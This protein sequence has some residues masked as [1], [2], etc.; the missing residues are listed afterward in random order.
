MEYGL[1]TLLIISVFDE[2]TEAWGLDSLSEEKLIVPFS[3]DYGG[4]PYAGI[5]KK[6]KYYS[7]KLDEN[8]TKHIAVY[9][10]TDTGL[11]IT[12]ESI[13]Y[14]DFPAIEWVLYI[15]NNGSSDT[16]ILENILPLDIR[17]SKEIGNGSFYKLHYAKGALCCIDDFA[18]LEKTFSEGDS[19]HIQPG[20]GRS[21]S[22]YM[23]FFN[24]DF[25][26]KGY[27]IAIGWTGEWSADFL[28]K[29][30]KLQVKAGM[31]KT[32]LKLYPSEQ[33]R[34]PRI[35]LLHWNGEHIQG[36]NLL[37]RFILSHHR[38]KSNSEPLILPVILSD[39]G[40]MPVEHHLRNIERIIK[41]ELPIGLYWIDAEWFGKKPWHENTGNWILRKEI[42]PNGF[43][44][45][46]DMLHK[47]G[48]KF[49]LWFEPQRVCKGTPWYNLK[50]KP[51]WLLELGNGTPEYKQR[52]INWH[53]PHE[54]PRWII[55]ESRRNQIAEDDM[56]FNIGNP[57]ARNFLINFLSEKI[58]E[59]G[60]D[61]YREDFNIAPLEYWQNADLP[62]RQGMT[63]IRYIEGLYSL[64]DELLKRH[65]H[66]M[67]DNCASG[68][69][70]IDLETISRSTALWRTDWPVDSIHKQ[71]HSYGLFQWV[72]LSMTAGAVLSKGNEY[73]LRSSMT[74]GLMVQL[75]EGD[76]ED[77]VK[78]GKA[79]LEQYL[80]IQKYF[81]GDF[82][83]LNK[84]SKDNDVWMAWQFDCPEA[85]EGMIQVF[86]RENS[87]NDMEVFTLR[88]LDI[89]AKYYIKNID[90]N[91][92][93]EITAEE[94]IK[95][96]LKITIMEKPGSAIFI[97]NKINQ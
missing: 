76:D 8:R 70:R 36:N 42:Y 84:Y 72:P 24:V 40:G 55:Y 10:D 33:I 88:G 89:N 6:H 69:R 41:N 20:G 25:G 74:S 9:L 16:P 22:E 77:K 12:F 73:N 93:A 44:P 27:I 59:F 50:E 47:H 95:H 64:W 62:D 29:D 52:D 18:P 2:N 81:Y 43:K 90:D 19:L 7:E 34:T 23:P 60:L 15:K 13:V 14:S 85:G 3:F 92:S 79:L 38:P 56:L 28:C 82:Y 57:D 1:L 48:R 53:I 5:I 78:Y 66:L 51:G 87:S 45:I 65:P 80:Q 54:D 37:R 11:E 96:G 67:I 97:Y 86:R 31:A 39:W 63:E 61:W 17:F 35:L 49:L 68:G 58:I 71:C 46:S 26:N 91:S 30:N 32:H 75:W 21:S 94:L 4:R 83:P